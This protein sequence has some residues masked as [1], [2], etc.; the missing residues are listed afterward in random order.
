VSDK[1]F[2][3]LYQRGNEVQGIHL[4]LHR[5]T[6]MMRAFG[7][8]QEKMQVL[9]IG[10]TNG[11]GSVAAMSE[12]ILRHGG[13]RT[14]LYT[15]PHLVKLEERIR[16]NG[17]DI[18]SRRLKAIAMRVVRTES[19]LLAKDLL[20]RRLS[21]FEMV[22]ACAFLHFADEKVDIAVM[23]VGLGGLLDATNIVRPGACIITGVSYDHEDI[24]GHT[25]TS[26]AREKAGIIKPGTPVVSGCAAPAARN[27]V[28]RKALSL[29]APL[30]EIDS[31]CT[32]RFTTERHGRYTVDLQTPRRTYRRLPLGLAGKHQARNAAMAVAALEQL[33]LPVRVA[34]IRQGL[35]K[36]RWPGRLEEF[37]ARR[38]T[39]LEGAHNPE[40]AKLL[41]EF[42]RQQHE[43]EVHLVFGALRDKD[44]RKMSNYLFPLAKSI[45]VAA[46]ANSRAVDPNEVA[47]AHSGHRARMRL[48]QDAREAL[49]AAWEECPRSGLVVVTGSLYLI[50][51]LLP[52]VRKDAA[53]NGAGE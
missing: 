53:A 52:V 31:N 13:W 10:G 23:E 51:E 42:L 45:H 3:F 27:I 49:V 48:H 24:L 21:Y 34:D 5:I 35:A 43:S 6:A 37:R 15:S 44:F 30:I 7:D 11:K 36:T 14:G 47:A 28:R 2:D 32:I 25:L 1:V 8:P 26:I 16:V 39:L 50:G 17:Q 12:S 41:R 22:T 4:G 40:G 46:P 19:A 33:K 9:H 29:D 20:D 38:R 18:S